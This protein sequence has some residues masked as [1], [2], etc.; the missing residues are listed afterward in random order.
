MNVLGLIGFYTYLLI[1]TKGEKVNLA[2]DA[3]YD[4][5]VESATKPV[6]NRCKIFV[7]GG[8]NL[9]QNKRGHNIVVINPDT[10]EYESVSFDTWDNK[11]EAKKMIKFLKKVKMNSVIIMAIRDSSEPNNWKD[12]YVSYVDS[13]G[14]ETYKNDVT[15]GCPFIMFRRPW[16]MITQKLPIG[17]SGKRQVP[18]W[19]DCRYN[20]KKRGHRVV[21]RK[22]VQMFPS[23]PWYRDYIGHQFCSNIDWGDNAFGSKFFGW[24]MGSAEINSLDGNTCNGGN[25]CTLTLSC[26]PR[27][28]AE[29]LTSTIYCSKEGK[30]P[31][32]YECPKCESVFGLKDYWKEE[33]V[34]YSESE[35]FTIKFEV[36]AVRRPLEQ[37]FY[38][39]KQNNTVLATYR[40]YHR[41]SANEAEIT[42][43]KQFSP[44]LGE[45]LDTTRIWPHF[46]FYNKSTNQLDITEWNEDNKYSF[47]L[48]L[49]DLN[50]DYENKT[51]EFLVIDAYLK[52]YMHTYKK[53]LRYDD[54]K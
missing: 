5:Y 18:S 21:I 16:A 4:I 33:N 13:F 29:V 53:I 1:L 17:K 52:V 10:N 50:E 24:T 36:N 9:C 19:K 30:W 34:F 22:N 48:N 23:C 51:T 42:W 41:R 2:P 27:Y 7:N 46:D 35:N 3:S 49:Y 20:S 14:S 25:N 47:T 45:K 44:Q 40:P 15:R 6:F 26:D 12:K 37:Y 31:K 11:H 43:I 8:R 32:L 39:V 28:S 38:L 54:Q